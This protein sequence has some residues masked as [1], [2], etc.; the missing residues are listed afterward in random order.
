MVKKIKNSE[1][2][3][4]SEEQLCSRLLSLKRESFNLRFQK[5]MTDFK[6]TSV[7]SV[8]RKNIARINTEISKRKQTRL[9]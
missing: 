8:V 9:Q 7:I 2:S 6:D 5:V 4:L 3:V 1:I